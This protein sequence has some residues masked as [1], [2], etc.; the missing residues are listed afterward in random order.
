MS[1]VEFTVKGPLF[2]N[3]SLQLGVQRGMVNVL[4][5]GQKNVQEQLY[6]GHGFLTGALS[7]S[8]LGK[9]TDATGKK[10][11]GEIKSTGIPYVYWVETGIRSG[12]QTRFR[13]YHM[14]R[15]TYRKLTRTDLVQRIMTKEIVKALGGK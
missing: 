15:D 9:L 11:K 13:G 8:I 1:R 5:E 3:R 7:R 6:P 10:L 12:R 4:L 2:E 14:F